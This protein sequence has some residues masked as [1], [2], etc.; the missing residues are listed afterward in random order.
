[1][2]K[3]NTLFLKNI[4]DHVIFPNINEFSFQNCL[5]NINTSGISMQ[6]YA[7]LLPAVSR[8]KWFWKKIKNYR[9]SG[10]PNPI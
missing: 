2:A 1:L 3:I 7:R 10:D 8:I 9:R 4:A 6:N 5:L